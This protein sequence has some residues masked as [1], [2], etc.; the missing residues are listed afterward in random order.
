MDDPGARRLLLEQFEGSSEHIWVFD[1]HL[2]DIQGCLS[3]RVPDLRVCLVN[4][5]KL[6]D[7]FELLVLDGHHQRRVPQPPCLLVLRGHSSAIGHQIKHLLELYVRATCSAVPHRMEHFSVL[8]LLVEHLRG[9]AFRVSR[10]SQRFFVSIDIDELLHQFFILSQY[11]MM[12]Y[13]L[14]C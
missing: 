9:F 3:L 12:Q 2:S 5:H 8:A 6:F 1:R 7:R 11:G 4:L 14:A 10:V 13:I